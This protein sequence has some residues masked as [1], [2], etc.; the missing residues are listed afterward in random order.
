MW[1][2]AKS[3]IPPLGSGCDHLYIQT[4]RCLL[5]PGFYKGR[6]IAEA[7]ASAYLRGKDKS[8]DNDGD[9]GAWVRTTIGRTQAQDDK[10]LGLRSGSPQTWMGCIPQGLKP[11]PF[12]GA[13]EAK[14]EGLAYLEATAKT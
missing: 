7:E 11:A 10:S 5:S 12:Y 9:S 14:P 8:K 1:K 3:P 2:S 4:I 13:L 6:L